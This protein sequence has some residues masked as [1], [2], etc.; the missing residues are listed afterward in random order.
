MGIARHLRQNGVA[1]QQAAAHAEAARQFIMAEPAT[2]S[3]LQSLTAHFGTKLGNLSLRITVRLG[4]L[5]GRIAWM[6]QRMIG[7]SYRP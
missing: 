2:K 4:I 1:Q 3:D 5:L 7:L 6:R